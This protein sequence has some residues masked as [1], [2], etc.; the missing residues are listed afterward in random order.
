MTSMFFE[1]DLQSGISLALRESK[2]VA[3]FVRDDG[4]ES[5]TWENEY[6]VDAQVKAA[7]ADRAVT[8]RLQAGS[9]EAAFL[10]AYYPVQSVPTFTIIQYGRQSSSFANID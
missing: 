6:L 9:P 1:G 4:E 5:S 2:S 8:L 10:S 3:C 7:L